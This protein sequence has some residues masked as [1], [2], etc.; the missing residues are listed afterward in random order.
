MKGMSTKHNYYYHTMFIIFLKQHVFSKYF[1]SLIPQQLQTFYLTSQLWLFSLFLTSFSLKNSNAPLPK[2]FSM[3]EMTV[4]HI[5]TTSYQHLHMYYAKC[6]SLN[7]YYM[8]YSMVSMWG[9][10]YKYKPVICSFTT[11]RTV[12]QEMYQHVVTNQNPE[13]KSALLWV[14]GVSL[15]QEWDLWD[16]G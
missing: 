9:C 14:L 1:I 6:S 13:F 11:A 8:A 16:C 15:L 3:L 10:Y 5:C 7:S 4:S 12:W 2:D